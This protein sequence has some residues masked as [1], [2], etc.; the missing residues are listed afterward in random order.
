MSKP[1]CRHP[2]LWLV[3][4]SLALANETLADTAKLLPP[5]AS[6]LRYQY[7]SAE[8][9]EYFNASGDRRSLGAIYQEKLQENGLPTEE[10]SVYSVDAGGQFSQVRHDLYFEY[11]ITASLNFGLWTHYLDRR[12][13]YSA[14]L[15]REAGWS[16]LSSPMQV[17]LEGAVAVA[18]SAGD[19]SASALGDTVIGL[20]YRL[21]GEDNDA[22]FRLAS[23]LGV[24][25][26]TGHVADPLKPGD[27]SLGDG[28][29]DAGIWFAWDWEPD[30]RW[31]FNLHTRHEYQF[32]GEEDEADPASPGTLSKEFQPGFYHYAELLAHR[33]IPRPDFNG[34][35]ALK[36]IYETEAVR[37][38]QQYDTA[39]ERYRGDLK[40][41]EGT[42]S[43]LLRL[44]PEIGFNL[45]PSGIPVS[46]RLYY[47]L[48][49][50]GK[51]SLAAEYLGLRFDVFW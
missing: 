27:I 44:E 48:P 21:I 47:G 2:A 15:E 45:Y 46:A 29:T 42:D 14:S 6:H 18:D 32:K 11:G 5:G 9:D 30:D 19:G 4:S 36:V 33:R 41:V 12:L 49:L 24:R 25:L 7:T 3:A 13:E 38:E 35:V 16:A 23:T 28:Q 39:A 40:A 1:S 22:P 20:K 43:M 34:F 17:G 26:P 31:L 50:R 51:N 37:R 10:P 8:A